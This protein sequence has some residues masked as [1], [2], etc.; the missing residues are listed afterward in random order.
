MSSGSNQNWSHESQHYHVYE[1]KFLETLVVQLHTN[2]ENEPAVAWEVKVRCCIIGNHSRWYTWIVE[3]VHFGELEQ[4][5]CLAQG[6]Y[7]VEYH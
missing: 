2:Y 1:A 7:T 5:Q 4:E 6:S 3:T